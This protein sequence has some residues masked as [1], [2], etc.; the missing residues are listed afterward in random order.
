MGFPFQTSNPFQSFQLQQAQPQQQQPQQPQQPQQQFV[1]SQQPQQPQLMGFQGFPPISTASP[2]AYIGQGMAAFAQAGYGQQPQPV[3]YQQGQGYSQFA[4]PPPVQTVGQ[5]N[6]NN[7]KRRLAIPPSPEQSPEGAYVGQHSQGIGG[8]YASSYWTKKA[9]K[10]WESTEEHL[11]TIG[12]YH[13]AKALL[14]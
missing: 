2:A 14:L 12:H 8:H 5:G 1:L 9:K 11:P 4:T 3:Y 13:A 7:L 6:L 10:Y